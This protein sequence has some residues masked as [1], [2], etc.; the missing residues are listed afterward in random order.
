MKTPL[1]Q[2]YFRVISFALIITTYLPILLKNLPPI[3]RSHH[4]WTPIWL[5]SLILLSPKTFKNKFFIYVIVYQTIFALLI[6][7][8]FWA[9]IDDWTVKSVSFDIYYITIAVSM[10]MYFRS[11]EDYTGL[12][13]II[14]WSLI[15][16]GITAI[17]SLYSSSID[18][19]YARKVISGEFEGLDSVLKF[20]GGTYGFSA[21]IVCLFPIMV[22]YYRYNSVSL[23][24]RTQIILFAMLCLFT[25]IRIQIFANILIS[26]FTIIFS[27]IAKKMS[28]RSIITSMTLLIVI[29]VI[30]MRVYSDLLILASRPFNVESEVY[31]KFND[32]SQYFIN[33]SVESGTKG[34]I[35]RFPLLWKAFTENP[36]LGHFFSNRGFKI[37]EGGHIYFM[38]R[39][40]AFGIINFIPFIIIYIR[41][42]KTNLRIF[43][44]RFN[45]FFLLSALSIII[46]GLMK[47]L[48]SRELWYMYFFIVP[49]LYYLPIL[50][51]RKATYTPKNDTSTNPVQ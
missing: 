48:G 13:I 37:E 4:I 40:A 51:K 18:P 31:K 33:Q 7:F 8:N 20:G 2:K 9:D 11:S 49:G 41:H 19:L 35:D 25:I 46:M 6:T 45:F 36:M 5:V 44:Q 22:Y 10:I 28:L 34:R 15:F 24:S 21:G 47:N 1:K 39:L 26:L 16:V 42:I 38:Y 17:M 12:A 14:K 27:I 23:F 50:K 3:I 29:V 30:P 32:L 43:N